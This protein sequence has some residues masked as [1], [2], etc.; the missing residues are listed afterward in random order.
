MSKRSVPTLVAALLAVTA[1]PVLAGVVTPAQ[2]AAR[3]FDLSYI[4]IV[5]FIMLGPIKIFGPFAALTRGAD[6]VLIR[7]LAVRS[8]A[9][10][11]VALIAGAF[12]GVAL[13]TKWQISLGALALTAGLILVTVAMTSVVKLYAPA[14]AAVAAPPEHPLKPTIATALSPLAFPIIVTPYGMAALIVFLSISPG[15]TLSI[16]ALLA[17]IMVLNL[18]A[19]IFVRP[20]LRVLG[21]PLQLLSLVLTILQIALGIE[22]LIY[23]VKLTI[24]STR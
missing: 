5:L 11:T 22:I 24:A 12:V 23:G 18:L 19:M 9:V 3:T 21:L 17:G 10:A 7:Q 20:L 2:A 4:W 16:V 1:T 14:D 13:L 15:Q 8:T 6:P